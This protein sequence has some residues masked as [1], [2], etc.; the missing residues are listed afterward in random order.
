MTW[1]YITDQTYSVKLI[2][3]EDLA[4]HVGDGFLVIHTEVDIKEEEEEWQK[5]VTMQKGNK[6]LVV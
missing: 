1:H 2:F 6:V 4:T 3:P 5:Y